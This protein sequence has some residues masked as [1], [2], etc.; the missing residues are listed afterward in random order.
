MSSRTEREACQRIAESYPTEC[1]LCSPEMCPSGTPT[2]SPTKA[3]TT[4]GTPPTPPSTNETATTPSPTVVPPEHCGCYE[5]SD[6]WDNTAD[7]F[8]CGER[9][10]YE[11]TVPGGQHTELEACRRQ[12]EK[13]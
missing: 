3:P 2:V 8:T 9:I 11:Q 1:G 7:G 10:E 13:K 5:C 12:S 4:T 6:F